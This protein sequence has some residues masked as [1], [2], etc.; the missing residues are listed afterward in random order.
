MDNAIVQL[1]KLLKKWNVIA[2]VMNAKFN[3]TF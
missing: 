3:L 2:D 1:S